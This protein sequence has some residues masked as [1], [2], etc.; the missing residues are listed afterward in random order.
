MFSFNLAHLFHSFNTPNILILF[1]TRII[2]N[3]TKIDNE[4]ICTKFIGFNFDE[5]RIAM[6]E[7]EDEQ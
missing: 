2:E 5:I 3:N 1:S 4:D 6:D 7:K